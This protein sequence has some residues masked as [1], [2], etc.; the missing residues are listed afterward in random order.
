MPNQWKPNTVMAAEA[1]TILDLVATVVSNLGA[2]KKGKLKVCTDCKVTCDV[3]MLDRI[4]ASQFVLDGG[5][6][7]SKIG[8]LERESEV[9]FECAHVKTSNDNDELGYDYER[10]LFLE[11]DSAAKEVREHVVIMK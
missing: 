10:K 4:K 2:K 6:I 1:L 7:I 9:K 8:Q 5:G 11:C 3:L